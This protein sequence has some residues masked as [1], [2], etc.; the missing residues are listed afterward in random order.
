MVLLEVFSV[1]FCLLEK[2]KER[3]PESVLKGPSNVQA[4]QNFWLNYDWTL[5]KMSCYVNDNDFVM[6]VRKAKW[7]CNKMP[8]LVS[9]VRFLLG[10]TAPKQTHTHRKKTVCVCVCLFTSVRY[11]SCMYHQLALSSTLISYTPFRS[12]GS[13]HTK[14]NA[15]CKHRPAFLISLAVC[16]S[17]ESCWIALKCLFFSC[18]WDFKEIYY[19]VYKLNH[20][21][22]LIIIN[23]SERFHIQW[24]LIDTILPK[25]FFN[26]MHFLYF[27][28]AN[29]P[30]ARRF[31]ACWAIAATFWGRWNA[32]GPCTVQCWCTLKNPRWMKFPKPPTTTASHNL[33]MVLGCKTQKCSVK[34]D[35][36]LQFLD[37]C[38]LHF[39]RW[40]VVLLCI[41][42]ILCT[43][44][45]LDAS[46]S[47][48][49]NFVTR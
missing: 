9:S 18:T 47:F 35:E 23:F 30:K 29:T 34:T 48:A 33:I 45:S 49:V 36:L 17:L 46:G 13:R 12:I 2:K 15:Q 11:T 25:T 44:V 24:N 28:L 4:C 10:Y 40:R 22:V 20:I 39:M 1:D 31:R 38:L 43:V 32:R 16:L 41:M 5:S 42:H 14:L 19:F 3:C 21:N 8:D 26:S 7:L 27:F 6:A 37:E